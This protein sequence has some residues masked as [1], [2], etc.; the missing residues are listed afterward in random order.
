M[1]SFKKHPSFS[2]LQVLQ[3]HAFLSRVDGPS[4]TNVS[5]NEIAAMI[6]LV[7]GGQPGINTSTSTISSTFTIKS[8][9]PGTCFMGSFG[10][11]SV[12]DS[13]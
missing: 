9:K 5:K 7:V 11:L 8:S 6:L 13:V 1:F 4:P 3:T 12:I 10:S 2:K